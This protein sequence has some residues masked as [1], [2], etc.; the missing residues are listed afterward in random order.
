M[1]NFWRIECPHCGSNCD[2]LKDVHHRIICRECLAKHEFNEVENEIYS[3]EPMDQVSRQEK[4]AL[5]RDNELARKI[6]RDG[7]LE[8]FEE[9]NGVK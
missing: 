6:N 4:S 3:D 9:I 5:L 8:S 7:L 2:L 1:S